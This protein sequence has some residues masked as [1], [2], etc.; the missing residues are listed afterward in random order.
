M[1]FRCPTCHTILTK[2]KYEKALHIHEELQRARESLNRERLHLARDV[3]AQKSKLA[4]LDAQHKK[5]IGT[6]KA[7]NEAAKATLKKEAVAQAT[8]ALESRAKAEAAQVAR[9]RKSLEI[10]RA[11]LARTTA[12][13]VAKT[14]ALEA[15]HKKALRAQK[16]EHEAA[17]IAV[18]QQAIAQARKEFEVRV[19]AG[20][21]QGI[22]LAHEFVLAE[23]LRKLFGTK[24]RIT[25]VGTRGDIHME[26]LIDGNPLADSLVV[27]EQ[28]RSSSV[29]AEDFRDTAKAKRKSLGSRYV[30]LVTTGRTLERR[31]FTG[32]YRRG[33][34][35]V[36]APQGAIG[37]AETLYEFLVAL[38]A[39]GADTQQRMQRGDQLL[40]YVESIDFRSPI[41]EMVRDARDDLDDQKREMSQHATWWD[42]RSDRRLRIL[43][44]A[45]KVK[46]DVG[47]IARGE[48]VNTFTPPSATVRSDV[49]IPS[50]D[51]A[52]TTLLLAPVLSTASLSPARARLERIAQKR[53]ESQNLI[54]NVPRVNDDALLSAVERLRSMGKEITPSRLRGRTGISFRTCKSFLDRRASSLG[55]QRM[56]DGKRWS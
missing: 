24:A 7:E 3:A 22:G 48:Q 25:E 36:V 41:E 20:T 43:A 17:K 8:K 2:S 32:F 30:V 4:N 12:T 54:N 1:P 47:A 13:Q 56:G 42:R 39:A 14:T 6:L 34:I 50:G 9:I 29:T 49:C 33:E 23:K 10:D 44:N 27:F 38:A 37:L 35:I 18:R 16:A 45:E 53:E 11:E 19:K 31:P 21:A 28:K 5:A 40:A 55:L 52:S 46:C 26:P 51:S 15:Q